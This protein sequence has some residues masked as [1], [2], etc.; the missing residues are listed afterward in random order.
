MA[1]T[2]IVTLDKVKTLE[3]V[4]NQ[5]QI[6]MNNGRRFIL[7]GSVGL[8]KAILDDAVKIIKEDN[9]VSLAEWHEV[10]PAPNSQADK[11]MLKRIKQTA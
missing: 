4:E 7:I 6:E 3:S 11:A 9:Q 8:D 10:S 1:S 2:Q 5:V